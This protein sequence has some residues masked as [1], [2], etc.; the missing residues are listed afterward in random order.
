M[1]TPLL[2]SIAITGFSVGFMHAAI[3]THWLPFVL[4]GRAQ[5]WTH[6]KTLVITA[7]AS[8]GH[9]AFTA[10]LGILVVFLGIKV[11]GWLSNVFP[12]AVS[13]I[14]ILFGCYYIFKQTKGRGGTS[15]LETAVGERQ[16]LRSP[17]A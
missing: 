4:A 2:L 1:N 8:L 7:L 10:L 15:S 11:E 9:I 3:P 12:L 14:F 13:S 5:G 6:S 16:P 17:R